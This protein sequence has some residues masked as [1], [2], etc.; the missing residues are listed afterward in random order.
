MCS[1]IAAKECVMPFDPQHKSRTGNPKP[2]SVTCPLC[3]GNLL[4]QPRRTVDRLRS[5]FGPVK[6][7]RCDNLACQWEG[8]VS[9]RRAVNHGNDMAGR[10]S[11]P[12]DAHGR[13]SNVPVGFVVH[14]VLVAVGVVFVVIVSTTEPTSWIGDDEQA[15]ES[16]FY[17]PVPERSVDRT[18]SR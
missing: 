2:N 1:G 9:S 17:D 3:Q 16:R 7:Y 18:A 10:A 8:N 15:I 14:M 11:V 6:R 4:R 13:A 5:L 12:D